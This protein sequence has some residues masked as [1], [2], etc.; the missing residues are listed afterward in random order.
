[1]ENPELLL[2]LPRSQHICQKRDD[3]LR[4]QMF[5]YALHEGRVV[6]FVTEFLVFICGTEE[7]LVGTPIYSE[8]CPSCGVG[9]K[10][11]KGDE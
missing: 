2:R 11:K 6:W 8:T 9:F 5:W 3:E 1:M 10:K 4:L 7:R